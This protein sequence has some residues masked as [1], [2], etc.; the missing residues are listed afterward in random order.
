MQ[1]VSDPNPDSDPFQKL[2]ETSTFR[3]KTNKFLDLVSLPRTCE[4]LAMQNVVI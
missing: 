2:D 4:S 3:T 1:L